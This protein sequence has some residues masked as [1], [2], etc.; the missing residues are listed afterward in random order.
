[1]FE[2]RAEYGVASGVRWHVAETATGNALCGL[3]LS[4]I[5]R[6]CPIT[7]LE[8]LNGQDV[9]QRCRRAFKDHAVQSEAG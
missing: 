9:C 7:S 2:L 6:T 4:P 5:A 8:I 3:W 1:V